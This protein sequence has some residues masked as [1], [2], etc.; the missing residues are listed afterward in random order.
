[1]PRNTSYRLWTPVANAF[2]AYRRRLAVDRIERKAFYEHIWRLIHIQEALVV[3]LGTALATRL[4]ALWKDNPDAADNLRELQELVTGRSRREEENLSSESGS[5]GCFGGNIGAWIDL[6]NKFGRSEVQPPCPFAAAVK[7][8]LESTPSSGE[9]P[10]AFISAWQRISTVPK[11]Y[12][13]KN[14]S[15]IGRFYAINSLRNK[16]AHVPISGR[17]LEDVHDG[18][19]REVI[20]S[21]TPATDWLSRDHTSDLIFTSWHIPLRGQ[22]GN[23]YAGVTGSTEFG[24]PIEN[25]ANEASVYFRWCDAN[26]GESITWSALPFVYL[27]NELKVSLLFKLQSMDI[28]DEGA[29]PGEFHRFAA[30]VEPVEVRMITEASISTWLQLVPSSNSTERESIDLL[31][32][33]SEINLEESVEPTEDSLDNLTALELRSKAEEAFKQNNYPLAVQYFDKLSTKN[34]LR[35]NDVAMSKH[36]AALWRTANRKL[37]DKI[38]VDTQISEMWRSIELLEKASRHIDVSY[39]ARAMYEKSKALWH[40][41]EYKRDPSLLEQA[42]ECSKKAADL[43]YES[44]YISWYQR[45]VDT[46]QGNQ[47]SLEA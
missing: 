40:L 8:Y 16:L 15:R 34:D 1:M 47:A 45:L 38:D 10:L 28:D 46:T 11:T 42:T 13:D 7:Q 3:T 5:R 41:W 12:Q 27:D 33:S 6:L 31:S 17:I 26:S 43:G 44:A 4:F 19:R 24:E 39:Q 21:L 20:S 37:R 2:D 9:Q 35:Y 14:L 30:E 25:Y 36:G 29:L 18:L 23:Q 22:I 32:G